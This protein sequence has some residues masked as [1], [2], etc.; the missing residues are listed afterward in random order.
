MYFLLS[1]NELAVE[2]FHRQFI[3]TCRDSLVQLFRMDRA[4]LSND[5][6]NLIWE[7]GD[8]S[9]SDIIE[10]S[11]EHTLKECIEAA[12]QYINSDKFITA[13]PDFLKILDK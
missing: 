3:E 7:T 8:N 11:E 2:Y 12:E 6:F 10:G 4:V 5:R 9:M 1:F 13:K